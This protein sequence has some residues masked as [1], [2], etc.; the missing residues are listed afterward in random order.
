M[1]DSAK[2]HNI[3]CLLTDRSLP[4]Q[5]LLIVNYVGS[6]LSINFMGGWKCLNINV[7][8][9]TDTVI[10]LLKPSKEIISLLNVGACELPF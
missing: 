8:I 2:I 3:D 7:H 5:N 4:W 9:E 6:L 1:K 10:H